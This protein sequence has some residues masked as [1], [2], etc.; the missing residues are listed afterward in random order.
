MKIYRSSLGMTE[1]PFGLYLFKK[2]TQDSKVLKELLQ[3]LRT[4]VPAKNASFSYIEA[5]TSLHPHL[6]LSENLQLELGFESWKDFQKTMRPE[7]QALV[8]LLQRPEIKA[9]E[10]EVW[11]KFVVSLLKGV[12]SPSKNLLIDMNEDLH[13]PFLIQNFKKSVLKATQEKTVF[14]ATAN[15][16]L[17]LDCAHTIVG[18]KDYLFDIQTLNAEMVKKYWAA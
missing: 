5:E 11:E 16:S 15:S 10:C 13:S 1:R 4:T 17:W 2:E 3:F 18:R 8:T 12:M 6:S 9:Q 7:W 14:L